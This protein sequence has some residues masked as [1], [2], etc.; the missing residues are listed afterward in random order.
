MPDTPSQPNDNPPAGPWWS[1]PAENEW[2]AP[3]P[4]DAAHEPA[5]HEPAAHEPAAH[6]DGGERPTDAFGPP[7]AGGQAPPVWGQQPSTGAPAWGYPTDT[8]GG[9]PVQAGPVERK[10]GGLAFA[11]AL[12]ATALVAG[13]VGG[14]IG[15]QAN[16]GGSLLDSSASLGSGGANSQVLDRAPTSVAGIAAKVL[17]SVVSISVKSAS[18]S[19]TGSGVVIRSD[20]YIVTN[21]HVVESAA[22]GGTISVSFNDTAQTDLPARIVGRDPETDLA[23]IKVDGRTLVPAALGQSRS[24]VV[25]DPVIAIGSPLGLAGTVT[26]GI[27][28][29]LNRTVNVPGDNGKRTPLLNAVQTDAAINP[30]NS[31]GALVDS[32][33]RVIGINSAIATLGGSGSGTSPFG[34]ETQSGSIGVG[35]AI[36]VDEARS[37][38]EELIRT[39]KATHPAIGIEAATVGDTSGN[40]QRGARISRLVAGGSAEKG[41]LAPGDLITMLGGTTVHSVDELILAIREHK[42]GDTVT[43]TYVRAGR[44]ST[45]GLVLQDKAPN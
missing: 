7:P 15:S 38:A 22:S 10:R 36:P 18:S 33:G 9:S 26:S 8:I 27:I 17:K 13:G 25:G 1:R 45:A 23:V 41:G 44:T 30:G 43:V 34:G 16:N 3:T 35:F 29:A 2:G 11:G 12:L 24:L 31:G 37:V 19:G 20:G 21:N 39:G 5:A 6:D 4:A 32:G 14:L 28:S 42:V 40:G